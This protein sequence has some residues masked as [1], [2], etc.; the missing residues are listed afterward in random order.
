MS[1]FNFPGYMTF[2]L[3]KLRLCLLLT[4]LFFIWIYYLCRVLKNSF[5]INNL[6]GKN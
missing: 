2:S 1:D 3:F 5:K 6:E 4:Q